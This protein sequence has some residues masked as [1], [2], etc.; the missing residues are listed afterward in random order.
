MAYREKYGPL[1]VQA[2][3]EH[4]AAAQMHHMNTVHGGKADLSVFML[5]SQAEPQQQQEA[6]IDDVFVM[7]QASAIKTP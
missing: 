1:S 5:F 2:R 6:S 4:I 7:L 3:Q